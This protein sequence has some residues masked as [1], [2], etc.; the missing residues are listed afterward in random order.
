MSDQDEDRVAGDRLRRRKMLLVS[1]IGGLLAS[2]L[3]V[4]NEAAAETQVRVGDADADMLLDSL[5]IQNLVNRERTARDVGDWTEM[6]RCYQPNSFVDVSWFRGSGAEFVEASRR[7]VRPDAINF[8]SLSPTVVTLSGSRA[9]A[10][11]PSSLQAFSILDG[12]EVN[13]VGHIRLMWRVERGDH[14]WLISGL[15]VLY[16]RD[17]LIPCNPNERPAIDA[18]QLEQFRQSYRFLSYSLTRSGHTLNNDLPGVDRPE[19]IAALRDGEH[20]WLTQS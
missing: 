5:A 13:L 4:I 7:N 14:H 2:T 18:Q 16:I 19:T 1:G 3:P 15:R 11:T 17:L 20:R 6:A 10:E 12:I 8:H 9:L